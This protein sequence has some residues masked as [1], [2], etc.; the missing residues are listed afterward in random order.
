MAE[1][2]VLLEYLPRDSVMH[3]ANGAA[4]LL[5]VLAASIAAMIT[6]DTRV[7]AVI[8]LLSLG[9]FVLAKIRLREL[10]II[11]WLL[12]LF[13]CLNNIFIF[14]FAPEYGTEIFGTRHTILRM[15]EWADLT[16][17]QLFYQANVSLKYA[18]VIPIALVFFTTTSP[19]EFAASLNK[20]GVP[21]RIAYAVS[22]ALRFIPDIQREFRTIANAQQARGIDI[23]GRASFRTRLANVAHVLMP[24][25]LSNFARIETVSRAL[26][27][28]GFDRQRR[29]SWY[30]SRPLAARDVVIL[31]LSV[32]V[33]ATAIAMLVVNG[34]RFYN[35]FH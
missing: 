8:A 6:F 2:H 30:A 17:E 32:T 1:R 7:L 16:W 20:I 19:S 21:A 27:L 3:R 14:L 25:L 35:P 33:L 15:G 24:V 4:K 13:L 23:S 12:L 10:A 26:E 31:V 28:R 18:A 11:L 5:A 34:G 29:R 9:S 22:L